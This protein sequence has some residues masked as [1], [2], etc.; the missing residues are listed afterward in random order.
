MAVQSTVDRKK[1]KKWYTVL[2]TKDLQE[3][4]LGETLAEEPQELLGRHLHLNLMTLLNDPKK[5]SIT[6]HFAI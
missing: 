1:R 4:Y 2:A 3:L 6:V 5:Q